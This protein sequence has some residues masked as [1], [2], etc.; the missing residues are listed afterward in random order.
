MLFSYAFSA[1]Q[2]YPQDY[3]IN[4][5][6]IE[7]NKFAINRGSKDGIQLNTIFTIIRNNKSI[8]KARAIYVKEKISALKIIYK[9][10][11]IKI[12]DIVIIDPIDEIDFVL[13]RGGYN[14]YKYKIQ[15]DIGRYGWASVSA[16]TLIG[17]AAMDDQMFSTTVIPVIG[18]FITIHR[19]ES[20]PNL[21]YLPGGRELL[22]TSGVLQVS[23]FSYWIYYIIKDSSYKAK[24][25]FDIEPLKSNFGIS[26]CYYF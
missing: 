25:S 1:T 19:I 9:I 3:T 17:S 15:K 11:T 5:L 26:L 13:N 20:D 21:T 10:E 12:S 2:A 7:G 8:G 4:I 18:P 23:F 16:I 14:P 22:I 6:K 24:Y